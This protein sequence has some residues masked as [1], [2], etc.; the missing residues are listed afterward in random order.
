MFILFVLVVLI[1]V[2]VNCGVFFFDFVLGIV[3]DL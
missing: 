3:I 1:M 2:G